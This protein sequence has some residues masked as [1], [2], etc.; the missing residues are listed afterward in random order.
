MPELPEVETIR[1]DLERLIVGKSI[2]DIEA[3]S[4]KQVKPS[5][6]VVKKAIVGVTIKK[7]ERRA[8][9]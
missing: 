8:K 9:L 1:R 3:D 4:A 2:L 7:V 5:L 6:A